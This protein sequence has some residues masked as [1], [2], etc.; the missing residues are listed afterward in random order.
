MDF[1]EFAR[2]ARLHPPFLWEMIAGLS[3]WRHEKQAPKSAD[4]DERLNQ[5][6]RIGEYETALQ[7]ALAEVRLEEQGGRRTGEH[8]MV[9]W[10]YWEAVTIYRTL[11]RY[12]EEVALIRR[13]ARNHDINFRIF[14]K[15]YRSTSGVH[16]ARAAKFLERF[17]TARAAAAAHSEDN[18]S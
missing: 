15:R 1:A 12:D 3:S 2:K 16:E 10:Y 14:S 4:A 8:A 7:V 11:K 13:F 18:N 5:L 17:D 9:P 6:K